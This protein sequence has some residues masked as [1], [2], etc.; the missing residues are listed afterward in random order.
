MKIDIILGASCI[1]DK[2]IIYIQSRIHIYN[3]TP[4]KCLHHVTGYF[5]LLIRE[6]PVED[7]QTL[8]T[9]LKSRL[10]PIQ[11]GSLLPLTQTVGVP[12]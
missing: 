9:T 10:V 12:V 7:I 2:N 1:I 6:N 4:V 3:C 5:N 8:V 11:I